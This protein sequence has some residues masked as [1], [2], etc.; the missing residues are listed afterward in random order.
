LLFLMAVAPRCSSSSAAPADAASTNDV[1]HAS[2]VGQTNDVAQTGDAKSDATA[3]VVLPPASVIFPDAPDVA[4]G[5]DAG[6]CGLPPS[7]CADPS[8]D[9]GAC[10]GLQWV[11]YYDNP[12]C[13]NDKCVYTQRY[14][15]CSIGAMCSAGGCRYNGTTAAP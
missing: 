9:G 8:C 6:D 12:T 7:A 13:V 2:D 15:E 14:F 5:G 11:V 4:C 10:Y 3:D 1:G